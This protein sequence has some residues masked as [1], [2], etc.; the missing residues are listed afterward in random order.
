MIGFAVL[1]MGRQIFWIFVAGL[2]FALGIIYGGQFYSGQPEWVIILIGTVAGVLG[3]LLAYN[4]QRLAGV[5]A[6]FA[7]GWYL[8]NL[9]FDYTGFQFGQYNNWIPIIVG[10]ICSISMIVYFNWSA[11]LL[12]SFAGAAIITL[13]MNFTNQTEMIMLIAFALLGTAIQAIWF[14]QE[15]KQT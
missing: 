15:D 13:G 10:V 5:F 8:T 12:S 11:I 14:I 1:V 7:T 6:G 2:G 9:F 4:L 3:A